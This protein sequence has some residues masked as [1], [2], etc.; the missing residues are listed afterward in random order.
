MLN[1]DFLVRT[2]VGGLATC[3]ILLG[4]RSFRVLARRTVGGLSGGAW[5]GLGRLNLRFF[6]ACTLSK[7]RRGKSERSGDNNL[8]PD[9]FSSPWVV[10]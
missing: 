3:R 10:P 8:F 1:L 6:L 5:T 2:A 4:L 9:H 7:R